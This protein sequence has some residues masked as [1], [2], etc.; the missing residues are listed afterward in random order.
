MKADDHL[1]IDVEGHVTELPVHLFCLSI[2]KTKMTILSTHLRF[3]LSRGDCFFDVNF[4][5]NPVSIVGPGTVAEETPSVSGG[6]DKEKN[7]A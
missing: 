3:N 1:R 6:R 4:I 5:E 2:T 7:R